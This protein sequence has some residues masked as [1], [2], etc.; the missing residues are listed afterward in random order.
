MAE[1]VFFHF[2]T[3]NRADQLKKNHPVHRGVITIYYNITRGGVSR[4]PKFVLRNI[5]TALY[6]N[7]KHHVGILKNQN[8]SL[9]YYSSGN[10][11]HFAS[12][13]EQS[14]DHRFRTRVSK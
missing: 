8:C 10:P 14:K 4:D 13:Y 11:D 9:L 7:P 3:E 2:G 5:W 12:R 1:Q 6:V